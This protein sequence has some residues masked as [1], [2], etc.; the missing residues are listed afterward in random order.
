MLQQNIYLKPRYI[1]DR[2]IIVKFNTL[3]YLK[4]IEKR[5]C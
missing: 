5:I 4:E 2:K 3:N 1:K